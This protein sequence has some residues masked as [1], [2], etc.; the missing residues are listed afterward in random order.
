MRAMNRAR[1][2]HL[3][4]RPAASCGRASR[5]DDH[6]LPRQAGHRDRSG[7]GSLGAGSRSSTLIR[8]PRPRE[9][10]C[11]SFPRNATGRPRDHHRGGATQRRPGLHP[12]RRGAIMSAT[13]T[14]PVSPPG[15][16]VMLAAIL[17]LAA[18]LP[19]SGEPLRLHPTTRTTSS[20]GASRRSSS[21][22]ARRRGAHTSTST[23]SPISTNSRRGASTSPGPSAPSRGPRPFHPRQPSP[24]A[25]AASP[26][27]G[28]RSRRR[29]IPQKSTSTD[30]DDASSSAGSGSCRRGRQAGVVA[31]HAPVLPALRGCPL[32][33]SAR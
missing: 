33:T 25:R 4:R 1:W 23:S 11:R 9:T 20:S 14:R 27:R 26:A 24:P 5:T 29:A 13:P 15:A 10:R 21:P 3:H 6:R 32:G 12:S 2:G 30:L 22:R 17:A 31:E 18:A 8:I 16:P 19:T 28:Q 7:T